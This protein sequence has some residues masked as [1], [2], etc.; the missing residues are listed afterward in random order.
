MA[1]ADTQ[2]VKDEG[3]ADEEFND[4]EA[5][6][7][8]QANYE[9]DDEVLQ[10]PRA[11]VYFG[12]LDPTKQG[13]D[14]SREEVEVMMKSE[15]YQK[16][17]DTCHLCKKCW[18][19][20]Q[21]SVNCRECGGFPL[22]RSCPICQGRCTRMWTRNVKLSHSFHKANWDGTCGLPE[23]LRQPLEAERFTDN[24][25]DGLSQDLQGLSTN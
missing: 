9:S 24:S 14:I 22:S 16:K 8:A 19:E 4:E 23:H 10:G 11:S 20:G 3:F 7:L 15:P 13:H 25:E 12:D 5:M 18:Y 17:I 2:G 21:F 6:D 1:A